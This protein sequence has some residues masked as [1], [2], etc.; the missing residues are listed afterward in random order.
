LIARKRVTTID[1]LSLTTV[2][3]KASPR[4]SDGNNEKTARKERSTGA[5]MIAGEPYLAAHQEDEQG[6]RSPG[7]L[8]PELDL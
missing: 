2:S 4:S 1:I 5:I 6:D 8:L 3:A 7:E